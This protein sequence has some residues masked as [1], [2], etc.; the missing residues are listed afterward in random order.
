MGKT[1]RGRDG[2]RGGRIPN[3]SVGFELGESRKIGRF[4]GPIVT[5]VNLIGSFNWEG[6][7]GVSSADS[8]LNR[9]LG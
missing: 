6:R 5:N 3:E 2:F 8:V 9:Q 7:I 1:R 4:F